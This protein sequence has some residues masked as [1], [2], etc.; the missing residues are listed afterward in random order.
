MMIISLKKF[1]FLSEHDVSTKTMHETNGKFLHYFLELCIQKLLLDYNT[2]IILGQFYS[3]DIKSKFFNLASET[4]LLFSQSQL[5]NLFLQS[6]MKL[7]ISEL[8]LRMTLQ[9]S[10][11]KPRPGLLYLL[12]D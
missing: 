5:I 9:F 3:I 11:S 8:L 1:F 6:T 12:Q 10:L 4:M 2:Q 7:P